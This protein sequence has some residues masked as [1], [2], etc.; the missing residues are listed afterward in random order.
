M[1]CQENY[2]VWRLWRDVWGRNF[3]DVTTLRC[4]VT[5]HFVIWDPPF[6]ILVW[7]RHTPLHPWKE[8]RSL[9]ETL[10]NCWD[11]PGNSDE[12]SIKISEL[13]YIPLKLCKINVWFLSL[14][15]FVVIWQLFFFSTYV[16]FWTL[17]RNFFC[18]KYGDWWRCEI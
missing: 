6:S 11:S 5:H 16:W 7:M 10:V 12:R 3:N 18:Q 2:G 15:R 8:D 1:S 4:V 9:T 14:F 13:V 17:F